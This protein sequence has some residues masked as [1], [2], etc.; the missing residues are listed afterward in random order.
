MRQHR[1]V[2]PLLLALALTLFSPLHP[3]AGTFDLHNRFSGILDN[4]EYFNSVQTPQTI[5]G[6]LC[7][8]DL[9]FI[10]DTAHQFRLGLSY[11]TEFGAEETVR[12]LHFVGYYQWQNPS[13]RFF[14]GRFPRTETVHYQRILLTDSLDYYRPQL[15]GAFYE[16]EQSFFREN[17]WVDWISRQTDTKRETF[18]FGQSGML[19]ARN[20][21]LEHQFL[22]FH[23]AGPAIRI[24]DDH[25]RDNG[26]IVLLGGATFAPRILFDSASIG[27]GGALSMDRFRGLRNWNTATSAL[28]KGSVS[29]WRVTIAGIVHYGEKH[30]LLWGDAFYRAPSYGRID[31]TYRAPPI[32]G[33]TATR[34]TLGLHLIERKV[35]FSQFFCATIDLKNRL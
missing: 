20:L 21:Y 24:V 16:I 1:H 2:F 19:H 9:G 23:R 6:G 25:V 13:S 30:L 31:I 4:R 14:I 12:N 27:V 35:D 8:T 3:S 32:A 29:L 34:F 10:A 28:A 11:L 26:G 15:S 17:I 5:F 18:I 33:I 22:M 7:A